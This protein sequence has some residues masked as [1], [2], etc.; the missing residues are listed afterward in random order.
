VEEGLRHDAAIPG[1]FRTTTQDVTIEGVAIPPA[2]AFFWPL[3]QPIGTNAYLP[4]RSTLICDASM[5]TNTFSGA[6]HPLLHGAVVSEARGAHCI[7]VILERLPDLHPA[8]A[9]ISPHLPSLIN[10]ALQ[11]LHVTWGHLARVTV[12]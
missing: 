6:W 7:E 9:C 1:M 12:E 8:P 3:P 4:S 5:P 10:R 11:H 2:H